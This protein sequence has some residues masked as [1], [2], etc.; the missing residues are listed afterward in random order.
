MKRYYLVIEIFIIFLLSLMPLLWLSPKETIVG[1]DSGFRLAPGNYVKQLSTTWD[2]TTN[3]GLDT[4]L[5]RG[6]MLTQL[7]EVLS[8]LFVKPFSL[9]QQVSFIFWFFVMGISM[10]VCMVGFFSGSEY[11]ILRLYTSVFW[12]YNFFVL[13]GW[14]IT[15]RAKFSLF[16]ALPL[17]FLLARKALTKSYALVP[18]AIAFGFVFLFLNGGG[19]PPLYGAVF[20]ILFVTFGYSL[21]EALLRKDVRNAFRTVGVAIL[22]ISVVA[23]LN[24][25]WWLPQAYLAVRSYS[26]RLQSIGGIE[27]VL[28]WERTVNLNASIINLVRLQGIPDWYKNIYHPYASAYLTN[29]LLLL[30]SLIPFTLVVLGILKRLYKKGTSFL[31]QEFPLF[32]ALFLFGLL[33]AGGSHA[34]FGFIYIFLVK[35]LPG[36]VIFRSAIYKFAPVLWFAVIVLSGYFFN[37]FIFTY[38]KRPWIRRCIGTAALAGIL[39]FHYPYF[40]G[41]HFNWNKPFTTKVTIPAYV[42]TMMRYISEHADSSDRILL[43]P[44]LDPQ[45]HADSYGW[46]FWSIDVL[47]RLYVPHAAIVANNDG[48]PPI[49]SELYDAIRKNDE[50]SFIALTAQSHVTKILWRNDVLY[51]DKITTA[52]TFSSI[53]EAIEGW[54]SV[55]KEYEM[56]EWTLYRLTSTPAETFRCSKGLIIQNNANKGEYHG[57]MGETDKITNKE[58]SKLSPAAAEL[59]QTEVVD[60]SC[61]YCE[62]DAIQQLENQ[63][64]VT[65]P[66]FLPDSPFYWLTKLKERWQEKRIK[67]PALMIETQLIFA[68]KRLVEMKEIIK[69]NEQ[70]N[71]EE[72]VSTQ[73]LRYRQHMERAL[74]VMSNLTGRTKN[75]EY[76]RI[77]G[78]IHAH[79]KYLSVMEDL[80]TVSQDIFDQLHVSLDIWAQN[81]QE[82]MIVSTETEK[83]FLASISVPDTY[84]IAVDSPV[85]PESI[86]VDGRVIQA[87]TVTLPAG[88]HQLKLEY[89]RQENLFRTA[90]PSMSISMPFGS[91]RDFAADNLSWTD[92]YLFTYTYQSLAG[93]GPLLS[94]QQQNDPEQDEWKKQRLMTQALAD[95]GKWYSF[96]QM[97]QPRFGSHSIDAIFASRSTQELSSTVVL[98]DLSLKRVIMPKVSL[99]R[100]IRDGTTEGTVSF[101]QLGPMTYIVHSPGP[102]LLISTIQYDAG[103]KAWTVSPQ[104]RTLVERPGI[105]RWIAIA[106]SIVT[107]GTVHF[108]RVQVNEYAN[109]WDIREGTLPDVL[110]VYTPQ[111]F[112]IVGIASSLIAVVLCIFILVRRFL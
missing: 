79:Q 32:F 17:G 26:T 103:W 7:P 34:P 60:T 95:D 15:E 73:I 38:V 49:I 110:I 47:A 89:A 9:G 25:Y 14:F 90:T 101:K 11:W 74:S 80:H 61:F 22:F 97:I 75:D 67:E 87:N 29:P 105:T 70:D 44:E 16:A 21:V 5:T 8:T 66:R 106:K 33:F 72:L 43:L 64:P 13:Q 76:G 65:Y 55:Q 1:H 88:D 24:I 111:L 27:G 53:K 36:F 63:V 18:A 108:A 10:Y 91:T 56:G 77:L 57:V 3:F 20:L 28:S 112:F 92:N 12:M 37:L 41:T 84:V 19:N 54:V 51:S 23:A 48:S 39:L 31:W 98:A 109:A 104:I 107:G 83:F 94:I 102:C 4:S 68:T 85:A 81:I 46:G 50:A 82:N 62:P 58:L 6:F 71:R 30:F 59:V 45:F 78:T 86:S 2:T 100:T 99:M 40:L 42:P 69:R 52:K 93:K 96:Q 35:T